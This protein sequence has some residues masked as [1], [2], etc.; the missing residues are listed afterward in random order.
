MSY[1]AILLPQHCSPAQ[2]TF[3]PLSAHSLSSTLASS[4]SFMNEILPA[5]HLLVST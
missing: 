1:K 2:P 3:P 4:L 5:I